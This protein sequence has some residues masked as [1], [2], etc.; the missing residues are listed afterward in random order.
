M[1]PLSRVEIPPSNELLPNTRR[2]LRGHEVGD[3]RP[4]MVY[5]R[6]A[7]TADPQITETSWLCSGVI[8]HERYVLTSAAC[9]E[10]V[11]QFYVIS[12]T[13]R[14]IPAGSTN[15]CIK[16]GAKK[17]VWKCVPK[18]YVFD[19]HEFDNIRWMANDIAVV[20]VED[21]FNF[22]RRVRGCD[23]I[24]AKVAFNNQSEELEKPGRVGN[25]AGWGST[26]KFGDISGRTAINSPA[27]LESDVILISKKNCKKRWDERYHYIIDGSMICTK[28]GMDTDAMS[29]ICRE[30]EVNCKELV[31]SDEEEDGPSRR[32]MIKPDQMMIHDGAHYNDTRRAKTL[33]GG[34]CE[35]DHGGP[36]LIGQG[37]SAVVVGIISACLTREITNQCYGPYLYTSVW[38]NRHLIDCAIN[39]DMQSTCKRL[40]RAKKTQMSETEY[41]WEKHDISLSTAKNIASSSRN[42]LH[43]NNRISSTNQEHGHH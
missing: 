24:P 9:I 1:V 41:N 38:K 33:S 11:K 36:L 39:K 26:D 37:K 25:I 12:G 22:K 14:W 8:I 29:T 23:F 43:H 19:G 32:M 28:D 35:N 30:N 21:D 7:A 18:S 10:D 34:F 3:R 4:Y 20:K 5:L 6:P 16:Y 2:I 15:D 17:A 40:L 42:I 13:H 27:L 31:Y